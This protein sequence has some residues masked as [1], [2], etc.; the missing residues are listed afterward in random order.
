MRIAVCDNN[1][2]RKVRLFTQLSKLCGCANVSYNTA[3]GLAF[4][5]KSGFCFDCAIISENIYS[6][7]VELLESAEFTGKIIVITKV[8][9][10]SSRKSLQ[11]SEPFDFIDIRKVLYK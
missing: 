8:N 1:E 7:T 9:S 2:Q 5:V 10:S 6:E 4:D 11:I 3:K